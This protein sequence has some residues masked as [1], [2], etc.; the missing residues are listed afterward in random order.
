VG[1]EEG[2]GKVMIPRPFSAR[3]KHLEYN[4]I[5]TITTLIPGPKISGALYIHQLVH[6]LL[7]YLLTVRSLIITTM[8]YLLRLLTKVDLRVSHATDNIVEGSVL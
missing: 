2:E 4:L 8:S 3:R 1:W 5:D 6:L 7:G